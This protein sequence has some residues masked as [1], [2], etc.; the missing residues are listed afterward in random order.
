M[1]GTAFNK[2]IHKKKLCD[3]SSN[4]GTKPAHISEVIENCTLSIEMDIRRKI[5]ILWTSIPSLKSGI[6]PF[7]QY[8][9][10]LWQIIITDKLLHTKLHEYFNLIAICSYGQL[11]VTL[12]RAISVIML[13]NHIAEKSTYDHN[14]LSWC[15]MECHTY[16]LPTPHCGLL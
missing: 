10:G 3:I 8:G 2:D 7:K 15:I 6:Y 16:C 11:P 13:W 9:T 4:Y 1:I 14:Y 5:S 12:L